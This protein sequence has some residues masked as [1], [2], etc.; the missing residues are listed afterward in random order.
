MRYKA[1]YVSRGWLLSAVIF[2][3]TQWHW[4]LKG[5]GGGGGGSFIGA[6]FCAGHICEI[7]Y[8]APWGKKGV[9]LT[10]QNPSSQ[11][12]DLNSL[13]TYTADKYSAFLSAEPNQN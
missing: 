2:E 6:R 8:E 5:G 3:Q 1:S 12:G 9:G 4:K 10:F 11:F 13:Q 7:K